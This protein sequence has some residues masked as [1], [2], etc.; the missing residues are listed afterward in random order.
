MKQIIVT[1]ATTFILITSTAFSQTPMKE[2]NVGRSFSVI[3]PS[4]LSK[5]VGL[6]N[7]ASLQFENRA[8]N[9]AGYIIES[10]KEKLRLANINCTTINEFYEMFVKDM[11]KGE[12]KRKVSEPKSKKLGE[13]NYIEYNVSFYKRDL[14]NYNFFG[15][16]ETASAFYVIG[17]GTELEY[18]DKFE[19][20]FQK[21]LYSFKEHNQIDLKSKKAA[22]EYKAGNTFHVSLP[23]YMSK[24]AGMSDYS[25]IEYKSETDKELHGFIFCDTKEDLKLSKQNYTS[26]EHFYTKFIKDFPDNEVKKETSKPKS[27]KKGKINFIEADIIS[28]NKEENMTYYYLVG[29]V[30]SEKAYYTVISWVPAKDKD[31]YKSD[32]QKILYSVTE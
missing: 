3:L 4:Y 24:S 22:G 14:E 10:D 15:I 27:Q 21:I 32:F 12:V 13:Y 8:L 6:N 17:C 16:V 23:H 1:L 5:T 26:I 18:I 11:H 29:I 30:E 20:D 19:P 7:V 28:Y 9:V 31:K 25:T 2:Y